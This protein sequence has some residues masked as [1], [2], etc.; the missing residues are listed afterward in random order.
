MRLPSRSNATVPAISASGEWGVRSSLRGSVG[1]GKEVFSRC[2]K[3]GCARPRRV[4]RTCRTDLFTLSLIQMVFLDKGSELH[5]R[6]NF[7]FP[8]KLACGPRSQLL[9]CSRTAGPAPQNSKGFWREHRHFQPLGKGFWMLSK[10]ILFI[11]EAGM[12]SLIISWW[13]SGEN[14]LNCPAG[15]WEGI[16]FLKSNLA[17]IPSCLMALASENIL[18]EIS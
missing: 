15:K 11:K 10:C 12:V 13:G 8:Q 6:Q 5:D 18:Q 1:P 2:R 3:H 7:P 9:G 16:S 14:W 17:I 4:Y